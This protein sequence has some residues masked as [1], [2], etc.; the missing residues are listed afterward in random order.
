MVAHGNDLPIYE[1]TKND[2]CD[3]NNLDSWEKN[4]SFWKTIKDTYSINNIDF[5]TLIENL[6]KAS[7]CQE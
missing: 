6:L 2:Q 1:I 3:L 4:F 7:S 5:L